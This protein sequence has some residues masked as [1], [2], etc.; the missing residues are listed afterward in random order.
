ME[1]VK[2][3]NQSSLD[4]LVV[5]ADTLEKMQDIGK[6]ILMSGFAPDHFKKDNDAMGVMIAIATGQK[7]GLDVLQSMN[8]IVPI[9][10]VPTLKGDLIRS[11]IKSHPDCEKWEE[12]YEGTPGSDDFAHVLT[13][14]R[15]GFKEKVRRVS[16]ADAKRYGLYV[17]QAMVNEN[18]AKIKAWW[19]E[20]DPQKKS[21]YAP[22]DISKSGWYRYP[23]RMLMYRNIGFTGRDEFGDILMDM[24]SYEERKDFVD[25]GTVDAEYT[26]VTTAATTAT[27]K[28]T[29][30]KKAA[31]V[32]EAPIVN[33]TPVNEAAGETIIEANEIEEVK[34]EEEI[35]PVQEEKPEPP[36]TVS[37]APEAPIPSFILILSD[38]DKRPMHEGA[39]FIATMASMFPH[40]FP[41]PNSV[42]DFLRD[43]GVAEPKTFIRTAPLK[44][45]A[46]YFAHL[47][48]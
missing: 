26:D 1:L 4:K 36:V 11:L 8:N 46:K 22:G 42:Y 17:D 35:V 21:K 16:I 12:D 33:E 47:T 43:Q 6:A 37:E 13:V 3:T 27:T 5:N 23:E 38:T 34:P 41:S 24:P 9:K 44:E 18:K 31:P 10:G 19:D 20:R 7:L 25:N 48:Q 32:Q 45:I 15:K 30:G 14:K 28:K 29:A 2:T 40:N 39:A